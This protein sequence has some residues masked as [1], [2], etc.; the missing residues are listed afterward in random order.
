MLIIVYSAQTQTKCLGFFFEMICCACGW[1][2]IITEFLWIVRQ[3]SLRKNKNVL[4]MMHI[5]KMDLLQ[6]TYL[7]RVACHNVHYMDVI[8]V[9]RHQR[10]CSITLQCCCFCNSL[11]KQCLMN[12][13]VFICRLCEVSQV[14]HCSGIMANFHFACESI[15]DLYS[16]V[17]YDIWSRIWI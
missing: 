2:R 12:V 6:C 11:W 5:S 9:V 7:V 13:H 17:I 3:C 15:G 4:L 8:V 14:R 16:F 1:V 10:L